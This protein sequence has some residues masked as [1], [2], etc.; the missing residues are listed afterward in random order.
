MDNIN[1]EEEFSQILSYFDIPKEQIR[2]EASFV[3]DFGFERFQFFVLAFYIYRS[4]KITITVE[5]L[6]ELRT[7]GSAMEFIRRKL[8]DV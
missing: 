5:D 7:I 8:I 2:M 1:L 6:A 4:F 3:E